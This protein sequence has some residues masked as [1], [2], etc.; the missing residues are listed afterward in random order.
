MRLIQEELCLEAP[1]SSW[2]WK[3]KW[4]KKT[5]VIACTLVCLQCTD[6]RNQG[7]RARIHWK[8]CP[9]ALWDN[10]WEQTIYS[11]GVISSMRKIQVHTDHSKQIADSSQAYH[12]R[13]STVKISFFFRTCCASSVLW[14]G[15]FPSVKKTLARQYNLAVVPTS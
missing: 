14:E 11:D 13:C 4:K 3:M 8:C 15:I 6:W 1:A 12:R 2:R 9:I 10:K 5:S 7:H